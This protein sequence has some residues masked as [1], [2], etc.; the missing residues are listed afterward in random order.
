[1]CKRFDKLVT[2]VL[3]FLAT[4][5]VTEDSILYSSWYFEHVFHDERKY[6]QVKQ[7]GYQHALFLS[8]QDIRTAIIHVISPFAMETP[9]RALCKLNYCFAY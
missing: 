9:S 2:E 3:L 7:P 8:S 6:L 5:L 1:M 4:V